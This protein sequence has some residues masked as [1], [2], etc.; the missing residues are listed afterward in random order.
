MLCNDYCNDYCHFKCMSKYS[1]SNDKV[2][3]FQTCSEYYVTNTGTDTEVRG[4][5]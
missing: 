5:G 4:A 3:F 2:V 1:P